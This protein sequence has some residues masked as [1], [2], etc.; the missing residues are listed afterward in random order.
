MLVFEE[1]DVLYKNDA[2][3]GPKQGPGP[4]GLKWMDPMGRNEWAQQGPN[5]WAQQG[6]NEWAQQ[7]PRAQMGP[8]GPKWVHVSVMLE[9]LLA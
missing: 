9:P 6:P 3:M 7:G 1:I 4:T 5:E 8:T 2:Q